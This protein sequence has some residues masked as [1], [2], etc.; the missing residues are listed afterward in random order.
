MGSPPQGINIV[1][2][3]DNLFAGNL[4]RLAAPVPDDYPIMAKWTDSV[5]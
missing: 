4:V 5:E 1:K 3:T 2:L